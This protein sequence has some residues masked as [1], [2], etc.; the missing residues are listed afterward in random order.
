[1]LEPLDLPEVLFVNGSDVLE[2]NGSTALM[3]K[4]RSFDTVDST[5]R[6]I[7]ES[8]MEGANEGVC[9]VALRQSGGYGRQGRTWVSPL[10]G[11]YFS[12]ALRPLSRNVPFSQIPSLSLMMSVAVRRVLERFDGSRRTFIK[13]PNDVLIEQGKAAGISL[14]AFG[15]GVCVGIG[16]NVFA[17]SEHVVLPGKYE[18]SYMSSEMLQESPTPAQC[19]LMIGLVEEL[20][21]EIAMEYEV[22]CE[23]GFSA[24]IDEYQDHM[25]FIGDEVCLEAL[26]GK[27][28]NE[29]RI[30]GI[31][32]WG[33]LL[34]MTD[35]GKIAPVSSGEVHVRGIS[36]KK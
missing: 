17:S 35:Q 15:D 8:L 16:V 25:A 7:R 10:G 26:D 23:Q 24:F 19:S 22:W 6:I 21:K 1:M 12:F 4:L 33:R 34:I 20:L 36:A 32:Q 28:L 30:Q 11:V 2:D 18:P 5:N 3:W 14:E 31:D 13:W 9:A 27:V 29:G